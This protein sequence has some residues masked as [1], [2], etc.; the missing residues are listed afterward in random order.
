LVGG[1]GIDVADNLPNPVLTQRDHLVCHDLRA[2]SETIRWSA[3]MMGRNG[4]LS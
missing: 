1:F 4:S 3:S 2:K